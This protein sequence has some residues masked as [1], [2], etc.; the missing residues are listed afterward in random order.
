M[1]DNNDDDDND[2]FDPEDRE[3]KHDI[4]LSE[5]HEC[6]DHLDNLAERHR[7]QADWNFFHSD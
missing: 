3:C 7:E 6:Q 2:M 1:R 4:L 5:C